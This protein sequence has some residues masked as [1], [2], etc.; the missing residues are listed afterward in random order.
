MPRTSVE[1]Q[2]RSRTV[3]ELFDEEGLPLVRLPAVG[4]EPVGVKLDSP[5]MGKMTLRFLSA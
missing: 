1:R 2:S 5:P 4:L 3:R